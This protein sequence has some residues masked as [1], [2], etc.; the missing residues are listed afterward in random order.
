MKKII[1]ICIFAAAVT[2]LKA[3]TTAA[4][5]FTGDEIVW[6]GLDFSKAKFIGQFDQAVGAAPA[7]SYDLKI[8]YIPGWNEL[9][10]NESTKYDIGKTFRKTIVSYDIGVV[11]KINSRISEDEMMTYNPFSFD[12][13]DE[14]VKQCVAR[15]SGD[16][17]SGGLGVVFIIECFHKE[18]KQAGMYV[19]FFNIETKEVLFSEK[20]IGTAKG[21]GLRNFW[22]GAIYH[23]LTQIQK[24]TWVAWQKKYTK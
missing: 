22:G 3:Q 12:N 2:G 23:V 11:D 20:M 4:D 17:N 8:K 10:L 16:Q 24:K 7:S 15:Y 9:I 14:L 21:I 6:Y 18:Q 19:T 1:V 13:P 5:V